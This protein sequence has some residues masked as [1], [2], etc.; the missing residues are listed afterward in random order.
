MEDVIA[1][2]IIRIIL[3]SLLIIS[4]SGLALAQTEP[5]FVQKDFQPTFQNVIPLNISNT[6]A[7][8]YNIPIVVPPGR[9]GIAMPNLAL[10]YNSQQK[11][12]WV[13]MGWDL[14]VGSI[15]RSTKWGIDYSGTDFVVDGSAEL[16]PR[17]D[18]GYGYYG[19]KIEGGFTK[20]R[21]NY[22][23]AG[24]E[25]TARDGTK[26]YYGTT[27]ASTQDNAL[28]VFKW[29]LNRV[30]DTNGNT[31]TIT[32][33]RDTTNGEIYPDEIHYPGNNRVKFIRE[34][35]PR[36]D[37]FPQYNT[38]CKVVTAYRLK[39]I[40][41]Y[42]N[43]QLARKYVLDYQYG[44]SSKRSR[45]IKVQVYGSN[46]STIFPTMTFTWQ[47]GGDG[48]FGAVQP[49]QLTT[50]GTFFRFA[51]INGDGRDDFITIS[52][53][54]VYAYL[55]EGNTFGSEKHTTLS[56]GG[57]NV[58]LF[59]VDD[60]GRADLV[61]VSGGRV[62][63]NHSNGNGTFVVDSIPSSLSGGQQVY[64]GDVNGDGLADI[65]TK[66]AYSQVYTHFSHG[67]GTFED[68]KVWTL[69]PGYN[70][71][72]FLSL[73]DV[74]GDGLTDI[75]MFPS[76]NQMNIYTYLS[77]G[78]GTFKS[79]S[80]KNLYS[81][82]YGIQIV[83]V[84]GDGLGDLTWH[85]FST[86]YTCLSLG[87]G[88][89][90]T[91]VS[92]D[93]GIG[94]ASFAD[95]N[96]DGYMDLVCYLG[97]NVNVFLGKG[98]GTFSDSPIPNN[99]GGNIPFFFFA[100]VNGDG[101]SDLVHLQTY[102]T[103]YTYANLAT[104]AFPDLLTVAKNGLGAEIDISYEPSSSYPPSTPPPPL[105]PNLPFIVNTVS[106]TSVK[107]GNGVVADT[108]YSY[109]DGYYDYD[110]R[111]FWG[112]N[113]MIQTNPDGTTVTSLFHQDQFRKGRPYQV[114]LKT[115]SATLLTRQ[116]LTWQTYPTTP[117]TWAFVKLTRSRLD[118]YNSP[119]VYAQEDNTYND[120]YGY[121]LT[122][123]ASGTSAENVTTEHAYANMGT[124]LWRLSRETI[125]GST[126][127]KVRETTYGYDTRGN[128]TSKALWLNTGGNP[129][130]S[131][132]YDDYG[133][134][135]TLTDPRGNTTTTNY[136]TATYT[137]PVKVTA[138]QTSDGRTHIVEY[139]YNYSFGTVRWKRDERDYE[140]STAYDVFGRLSQ[141]D[142]PDGGQQ[143]ITYNDA[144]PPNR[145]TL[146]KVKEASGQTVDTYQYFD[147]L[148]RKI[149]IATFGENGKQIDSTTH[150][151]TMGRVDRAEGPYFH[152]RPAA[153]PYVQ[154]SYD[155]RGRPTLLTSPDGTYVTV[156]TT[157]EFN[158]F[159]TTITDPD[160]RQ[161]TET[162]DYLGRIIQVTEYANTGA[163][164]TTYSYN[165]AGDLRQI[166]DPVGNTITSTYDS[167]GRKITM[168][169]PD[170]G[171]WQY[172][173]DANGNLLTEANQRTLASLAI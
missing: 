120:S 136:D 164:N 35:T 66:N 4:F 148:D 115:P 147:G 107:D 30:V 101:L 57:S 144:I 71:E 63:T 76:N 45:L 32:Y 122:K 85:L 31:M 87:D 12:G 153:Y 167:L 111:D 160:T 108:T 50:L 74:N 51:D 47:E 23:I 26:Y 80:M 127:V 105:R 2:S 134:L 126:S 36:L 24:W 149:A 93:V 109:A 41:V 170:L 16:V 22:S 84:N 119:T 117:T 59:D 97:G 81:Q 132:T 18:W 68:G 21:L 143:I 83:D 72:A 114:D 145:Y 141:V 52:Y 11:N 123:T 96:G 157:Y 40:E 140:T 104:G 69:S 137:Y 168:D 133:N 128:M 70:V 13:G 39:A 9:G 156:S 92:K 37:N 90:D 125:T 131:M 64:I 55:S 159:A 165:A 154:T 77:N 8:T 73:G 124:W 28:G 116:A 82:F 88:T 142:F 155:D 48:H 3:A 25:V 79:G 121:W 169:D 49:T 67:D 150:Y 60:D 1:T 17:T 113:Q 15:Q 54:E 162:R 102:P 139:L 78:D 99:L 14:E 46:G 53:R 171:H 173:Y 166:T 152:P 118:Y 29:C 56:N 146:T 75:V 94:N 100:D 44:T 33:Y 5:V 89:Y 151:D 86:V 62:Y 91:C 130:I 27:T 103:W 158:G 112:F 7:A 98:D 10:T 138:P 58:Y 65:V 95:I 110:T 106:S 20:Y 43:G 172:T 34:S 42:G 163:Q 129:T 61:S 6:G 38:L 161:K 135:K 19:A